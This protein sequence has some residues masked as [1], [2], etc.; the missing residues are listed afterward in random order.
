MRVVVLGLGIQ[1]KKRTS[2][3][4][5]DVVATV[6][7]VQQGAQYKTIE[8]V[9][10]DL[11][12]GALVCTPDAPKLPIL[13]HLVENK[14]HILVEKPLMGGDAGQL[15]EL[16]GMARRQGVVCYT[17]YNHRFEP[18][19]VALKQA[20]DSAVLGK[21]YS[22]RFF[23]GNGT[24][25]DV[26]NSAWRDQGFG[27]LPDLG[28]H[29]LDLTLFL[30]G[31]VEGLCRPW[32]ADRFENRSYDRF[33]FGLQGNFPIDYETSLISW[34]NTFSIDVH[35]ELGS[36]HLE[37]LCKWG[38][39]TLI[40]RRRIFPSGR[41]TEETSIM[42]RPD[43]TWAAEYDH[44]KALARSPITNIPNDIWIECKFRELMAATI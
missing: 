15:A 13:R 7:P 40:I 3:A 19:I 27:V 42:T 24:A 11:Y 31:P 36:A 39:S 2:I 10:L 12:D 44:F 22:A 25:R 14:K 17:A 37:G 6:D 35:G 29:L 26:R 18:Q 1:G 4:G 9:P 5:S 34:R 21:V 43:P 30:F 32:R 38:P 33:S 20:L 23:Y 41:P 8:E 28:S 16:E